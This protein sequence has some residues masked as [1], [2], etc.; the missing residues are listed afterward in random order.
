[1][2]DH[3]HIFDQWSPLDFK[4]AIDGKPR[5]YAW[6]APVW[7]G[8]HARRLE[9]YKVLASYFLNKSRWYLDTNDRNDIANRREYGDPS[10]LVETVVSCVLGKDVTVVSP[11]QSAT[12]AE[13][14]WAQDWAESER[15]IRKMFAWETKANSLGDGILEVSWD[16]RKNRPR[17]TV[18]DPGFYFPDLDTDDGDGYPRV[19]HLAWEFEETD[20]TS[21]RTNRFVRRITYRLVENVRPFSYPWGPSP[22]ECLKTDATW[23]FEDVEEPEIFMLDLSPEK[24]MY[25]VNADGQEIRDLPIGVDFIPLIHLPNTI[26]E[27]EHFGQSSVAKVLQ[28][29]DDVQATDTDLE[30]AAGIVGFPPLASDGPVAS[31]DRTDDGA[32]K[33]YGPGT[34]FEG[35]LTALDTSK[36]LDAL[37]KYLEELLKRMHVNSGVPEAAVGRAKIAEISSGI[38]L[39]LHFINLDRLVYKMR[40]IR[41]EKYPLPFKFARRFAM[42]AGQLPASADEPLITAQPG[43]YTPSDISG[44]MSMVA[45]ALANHEISRETGLLLLVDAGVPIEDAV[46]ELDRIAAED[47]TGAQLLTQAVGRPNEAFDYLGLDVPP[48]VLAQ[49]DL[50]MQA[51]KK[52]LE[53]PTP[54]PGPPAPN[55]PAPKP[56]AR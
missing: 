45:N 33:S 24:A 19:V 17:L 2:E 13:I 6:E 55:K 8:D 48:E 51:Q 15:V 4:R 50:A 28:I 56:P 42:I 43:A 3:E 34:V 16:S 36:A 37:L 10:M 38:E 9:A 26:S 1:V 30:G 41:D 7:V 5:P 12:D 11:D 35:K 44:V 22:D 47:F 39:R 49:Q 20:I 29:F 46:A 32:I 23:K 52:A 25:A 53:T 21:G 40:L 54:A 14:Q 31:G 18:W 27:D